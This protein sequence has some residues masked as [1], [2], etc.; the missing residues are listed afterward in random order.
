MAAATKTHHQ[1]SLRSGNKSSKSS[2]KSSKHSRDDHDGYN[3]YDATDDYSMSGSNDFNSD[4]V[5]SKGV[6]EGEDNNL[7]PYPDSTSDSSQRKYRCIQMT[8][9][10][11]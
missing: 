2:A 5:I 10:K 11:T 8:K 6:N 9:K 1:R 7:I 4:E 3:S